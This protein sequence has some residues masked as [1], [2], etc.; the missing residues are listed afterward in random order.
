MNNHGQNILY[1]TLGMAGHVNYLYYAPIT[2]FFGYGVVEYVKI[3]YPN[4]KYIL[5]VDLIRNNRAEIFKT[6][7]IL[8][9]IFVVYL[10]VTI[11]LDFF[12]R[13]IKIFLLG[14]MLIMKYKINPE[15][16]LSCTVVNKWIIDKIKGIDFIYS[17]YMLIT[18]KIYS[19]ASQGMQ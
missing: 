8:E 3:N 17:N 13:I 10:V 18:N 14:Q 1:I 19:Y 7:G 4:N 11:F 12:N 6:K 5:Q 15:F 16:R 9:I 2:L